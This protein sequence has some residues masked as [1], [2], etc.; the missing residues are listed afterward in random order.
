M[1]WRV[2]GLVFEYIGVCRCLEFGRGC[3]GWCWT[4]EFCTILLV[5]KITE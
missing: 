5:G 4:L 1:L 2:F 3:H